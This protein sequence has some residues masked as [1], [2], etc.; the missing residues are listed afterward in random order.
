MEGTDQ[1]KGE[2]QAFER[3]PVRAEGRHGAVA[4]TLPPVQPALSLRGHWWVRPL[5]SNCVLQTS[6]AIGS[7]SPNSI[8]VES[9]RERALLFYFFLEIISFSSLSFLL[10]RLDISTPS[11]ISIHFSSSVMVLKK[12]L[13][14]TVNGCMTVP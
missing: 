2:Q 5:T 6:K 12:H 13:T 1:G 4:P 3:K 14:S 10:P 7:V 11:Y 9:K 8:K